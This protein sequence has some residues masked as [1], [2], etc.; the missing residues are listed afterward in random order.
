MAQENCDKIV[1]RA[2]MRY[3][4]SVLVAK[5]ALA[6]ANLPISFSKWI[7]TSSSDYVFTDAQKRCVRYFNSQQVLRL[8]LTCEGIQGVSKHKNSIVTLRKWQ[9]R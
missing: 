9:K 6:V 5:G 8:L 1:K 4:W 2:L 3:F 7:D